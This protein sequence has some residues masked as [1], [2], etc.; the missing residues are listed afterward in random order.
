VYERRKQL[1]AKYKID[2]AWPFAFYRDL[3]FYGPHSLTPPQQRAALNAALARGDAATHLRLRQRAVKDFDRR[4]LDVVG[5][6]ARAPALLMSPKVATERKA[7]AQ[8]D[9]PGVGRAIQSVAPRAPAAD[10]V[11]ARGLGRPP[12]ALNLSGH[13][14]AAARGPGADVA[15]ARPV[16]KPSERHEQ[17]RRPVR[18]HRPVPPASSGR[19]LGKPAPGQSGPSRGPGP[20]R[21]PG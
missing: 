11:K 2:I 8:P 3:V 9:Q 14:P 16:T 18:L 5:A 7:V 19:G 20:G 17:A 1:L 12:G 15:P 21:S 10:A 4:R 6:T 13:P